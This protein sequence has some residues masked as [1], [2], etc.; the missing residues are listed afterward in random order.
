[1]TDFSLDIKGAR[2]CSG[3][4][5]SFPY[6][7]KLVVAYQRSLQYTTLTNCMYWFPLPT[8]LPV[9]IWPVQC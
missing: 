5:H 1:M 6:V 9:V 2:W 4:T 8:K 7:G 3:N